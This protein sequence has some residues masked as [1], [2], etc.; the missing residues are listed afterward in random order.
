M[1]PTAPHVE[2]LLL[3]FAYGELSEEE[4]RAVRVHLDGCEPCADA[5]R[6][7]QGVRRVMAKLPEQGAPD[8]GLSSLLAY[9]EQ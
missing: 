6:D 9:A 4:A 8:A 7:I 5:L 1:N 3:D 2:D